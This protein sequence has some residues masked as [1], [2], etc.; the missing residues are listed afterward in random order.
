MALVSARPFGDHTDEM[1]GPFC[2]GPS[3]AR[4]GVSEVEV[5][6]GAPTARLSDW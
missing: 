5:R 3:D 4:R 2:D 1:F 6:V